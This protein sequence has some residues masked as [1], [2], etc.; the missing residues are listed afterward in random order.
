MQQFNV[1]V[2]LSEL[3]AAADIVRAGVFQ[4]LS[5]AVERVAM[6]GAERWREAV[7]KA[8]LWEGERQAYADSIKVRNTGP[9]SAEIVSDYRYVEDIETGRPPYDMKRMLDS[10]MKV[11]VS[12]KGRRYLIIP[13]RHNTPGNDAL[14]RSMP[15]D[16]YAEAR[17][18]LPS[19]IIGQGQ[20]VSG[21]GAYS[22]EKSAGGHRRR[23]TVRKNIYQWGQRL[24][25]GLAPKLQTHHKTDPYAGMYRFSAKTP[26]GRNYS[27]YV[28]FRVMAE[29]QPG[30]II[31]AKPGLYI[32]K[33]VSD[34]LMADV[35]K[36]FG[37][38][39]QADLSAAG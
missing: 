10:S 38:A 31:P 17:H 35:E 32:A 16:V 7:L 29:G 39:I 33:K 27:S 36:V 37:A 9:Y 3:L 2:D 5:A 34:G 11:R 21:T 26:G 4:N 1:S 13:M 15:A 12:K 6:A 25:A 30:W 20:R 22:M 28:T 19:K 24:P 14:A 8:P 18:L 23:V